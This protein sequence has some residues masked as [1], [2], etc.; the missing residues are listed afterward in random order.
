MNHA[1]IQEFLPGG[2]GPTARKQLWQCFVFL[3]CV[4]SS[5]YFTF[6]QRVSNGY[7]IDNYTFPRFQRGFNFFQGG[8][9]GAT[10]SRWGGPNVNFYRNMYNF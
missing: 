8:G 7:F 2:P 3:L 6:L 9:G 5:N 1:L 4:L 10:F